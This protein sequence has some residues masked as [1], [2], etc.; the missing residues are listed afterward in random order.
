MGAQGSPVLAT[1]YWLLATGPFFDG[2][3]RAPQGWL[4]ELATGTGF[5]L[6]APGTGFWNW[7]LE[8]APDVL[9]ESSISS[10]ESSTFPY[11]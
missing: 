3:P 10:S 11:E 4:L 8:L 1:G 5:W 9:S 7:L 2:E 6:L